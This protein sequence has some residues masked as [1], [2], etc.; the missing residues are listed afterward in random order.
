MEGLNMT[1]LLGR[2]VEARA[3]EAALANFELEK[4]EPGARPGIYVAGPP[5]CGKTQFA[6][7]LLEER[8]Y[9][10]VSYD[11]SDHR[12]KSMIEGLACGNMAADSVISMFHQRKQTSIAILMDEIDGMAGGD[13]GGLGALVKLVRPKKTGRQKREM[14]VKCP[15]VCIGSD[16]MDKKVR[17]LSR[18]CITIELRRP[19]EE[20]MKAVICAC[21]PGAVPSFVS[22]AAARLSGDLHKL[23]LLLRL[24][25]SA[26][27]QQLPGLFT[28]RGALGDAKATAMSL[29]TEGCSYDKHLSAIA[30]TERTVVALLVHENLPKLLAGEEPMASLPIYTR[31]MKRL[32]FGDCVDRATFQRQIWQ[33]SEMSSLIK[34]LEVVH[35]VRSG[36]TSP[37]GA[38]ST[39]D[40]TKVLTKY[41]T[42]YNNFVFIRNL[43]Q[44]T[45]MDESDLYAHFLSRHADPGK[46]P[47]PGAEDPVNQLDLNRLWRILR[48]GPAAR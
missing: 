7:R 11:A 47:S 42:E 48:P 22:A 41:S 37:P 16:V 20:E 21:L 10:V 12:G 31:A 40:F 45:A 36:L 30:E 1:D 25:G 29:M 18:A 24:G 3:F 5:G 43:C 23:N 26:G 28:R 17:E 15:V 9:D 33:F 44:K 2:S 32:R 34:A 39:V 46:P 14:G 38:L 19:S 4:R 8:G 35:L 13:K 6:R 27:Q